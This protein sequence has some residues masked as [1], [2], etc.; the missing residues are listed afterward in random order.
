VPVY[1]KIFE[2]S[3]FASVALGVANSWFIAG[4]ASSRAIIFQIVIVL[5][6]V[7]LVLLISR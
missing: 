1:I 4:V 6:V 7:G 5:I 3:F 2:W